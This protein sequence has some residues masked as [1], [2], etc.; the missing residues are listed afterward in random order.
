[1]SA[2]SSLPPPAL[3]P[4]AACT[5]AE[6]HHAGCRVHD[7]CCGATD[8]GCLGFVPATDAPRDAE[9][10]N[11][12]RQWENRPAPRR[13]IEIIAAWMGVDADELEKVVRDEER[14]TREAL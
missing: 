9:A 12:V 4:C 13:E 8:C 7:A 3:S 6:D 14:Q 1:V 2:A 11:L 10:W 5:H